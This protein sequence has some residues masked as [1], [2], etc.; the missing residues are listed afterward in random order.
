MAAKTSRKQKCI[1]IYVLMFPGR[2]KT[3]KAAAFSEDM[4]GSFVSS[5]RGCK[6][7]S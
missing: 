7:S 2:R 5:T 1:Q 4:K 3:E 6:K